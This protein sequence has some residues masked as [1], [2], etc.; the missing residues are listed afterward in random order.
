MNAP[1]IIEKTKHAKYLNV[2][3]QA[4]S[5]KGSQQFA[6]VAACVVFRNDIVSFGW[7][8]MKSHPF[9]AKYSKVPEAI[10]LHAETCAIKNA[11]KYI[12]LDE[13]EKSALYVCRVKYHDKTKKKLVFG[14]SKPCGGCSKCIST[15]NIKQV[16]YSI[17]GAGFGV[18]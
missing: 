1:V 14:L 7:N 10:Y 6:R 17:E 15:F 8:E 9:Q 4:A 3:A 18:L 13:L 11:L 2:L 16:I 5:A 12:S